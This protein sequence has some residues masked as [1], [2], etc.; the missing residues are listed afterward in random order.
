MKTYITIL[1]TSLLWLGASE[2][3]IDTIEANFSGVSLK[4]VDQYIEE[5]NKVDLQ[6]QLYT[7]QSE[8]RLCDKANRLLI[9]QIEV[10][11]I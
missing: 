5:A 1:L 8:L 9:D 11:S 6:P 2:Y 7:C 10:D 3:R 4:L